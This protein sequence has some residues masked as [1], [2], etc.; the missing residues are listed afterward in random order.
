LIEFIDEADVGLVANKRDG[1]AELILPTKL[2]E[3]VWMGKPVIAART[4]T[5][6]HYFDASMLAFFEPGDERDLAA[7]ILE[8][9]HDPAR[10]LDLAQNA[11]RFFDSRDWQTEGA[12]YIDTLLDLLH[13]PSSPQMVTSS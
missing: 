6:S 9:Y 5:I 13:P 4:P 7:R 2:L 12:R 11:I 3:L 1:F 8:L 10:R